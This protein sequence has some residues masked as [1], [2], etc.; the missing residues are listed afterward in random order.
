MLDH[1][2]YLALFWQEV[3]RMWSTM[4]GGS[5]CVSLFPTAYTVH[6]SQANEWMDGC[7]MDEGFSPFLTRGVKDVVPSY[8]DPCMIDVTPP[9]FFSTKK[10]FLSKNSIDGKAIS[11]FPTYHPSLDPR[12]SNAPKE[13]KRR[14][15][16]T[17]C[18]GL[19]DIIRCELK[20][21]RI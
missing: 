13:V 6:L 16:C 4:I 11:S 10:L 5:R 3:S 9:K 21:S 8:C 2:D 15:D 1:E 7:S 20:D 12:R 18:I 17:V 19:P 14:H